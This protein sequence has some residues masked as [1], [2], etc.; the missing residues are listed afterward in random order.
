MIGK[1]FIGS[2]LVVHLS[3]RI[4]I[5]E[6]CALAT[7]PALGRERSMH[8]QLVSDRRLLVLDKEVGQTLVNILKLLQV[9]LI[10]QVGPSSCPTMMPMS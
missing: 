4:A 9:F 2:Q 5:D 3:F 6:I 8:L 1:P 7:R 10:L